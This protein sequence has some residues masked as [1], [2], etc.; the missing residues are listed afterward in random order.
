MADGM[1]LADF[2]MANEWDIFWGDELHF[3]GMNSC[4]SR[5][6]LASWVN[7]RRFFVPNPH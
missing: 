1:S 3:L 6:F 4:F 2:S 7:H 5:F